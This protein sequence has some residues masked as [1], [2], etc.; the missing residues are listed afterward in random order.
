M[1]LQRAKDQNININPTKISGVCG[2]LVCCLNYEEGSSGRLYVDQDEEDLI[3]YD[4]ELI[5]SDGAPP[6]VI[7][8][9]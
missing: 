8:D 3:Q 2:R 9:K 6:G 5:E 1:T 7:S 4:E